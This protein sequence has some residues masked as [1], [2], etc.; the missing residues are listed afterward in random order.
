MSSFTDK[1]I[2]SVLIIGNG[3]DLHCELSSTFFDY[4]AKKCL[5]V[6]SAF[7]KMFEK[8][9]YEDAQKLYLSNEGNINFWSFLLYVHYYIGNQFKIGDT[10]NKN[11]FDIEHLL[12]DALYLK[13]YDGFKLEDYINIAFDSL[14]SSTNIRK[15]DNKNV[16][17]NPYIFFPFLQQSNLTNPY[18]YLLDEL[19]KF[20]K[21]FKNYMVEII[22]RNYSER[23]HLFLRKLLKERD[24]VDL[25]NFNY[26]TIDDNVFINRQTNVHGE[27]FGDE[28]VIGI[29]SNS[30]RTDNLIKFTKTYRNMH[31]TKEPFELPKVVNHLL[32]YGH[33]LS[34][35]DFSYFHSLFDMYKLYDGNLKLEFYYSDYKDTEIENE[36]N[37]A[38]YVK[39]IYKLINEYSEKTHHD[40]NLLHRLLLEGRIIVEKI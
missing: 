16:R 20:E 34:D 30:A 6:V 9:L 33:S 28:I 31:R 15:L 12:C 35:A 14:K 29:D 24:Y 26:T 1:T 13:I 2:N 18:D 17:E 23:C 5:N 19:H 40:K 4:Y 36:I 7:Y 32:F 39:Q 22:D 25:I 10:K 21:S 37:H 27:L 8:G 3:F 11:W 38:N